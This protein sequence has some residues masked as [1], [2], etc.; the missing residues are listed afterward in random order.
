MRDPQEIIYSLNI[1]DI[2]SVVTEKLERDLS[3]EELKL[4]IDELPGYID[5]RGAIS[6]AIT[7]A[8]QQLEQAQH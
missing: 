7:D 3:D 8:H 5:W 1:E 4:V 6:L 2:Q